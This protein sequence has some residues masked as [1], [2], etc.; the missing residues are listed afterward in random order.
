MKR[1]N[2]IY[3]IIR[4]HHRPDHIII[5]IPF[6]IMITTS[7]P[8]SAHSLTQLVRFP[9]KKKYSVHNIHI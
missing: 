6:I 7:K 8:I 4:N 1:Y 3:M 9:K 5:I 2:A